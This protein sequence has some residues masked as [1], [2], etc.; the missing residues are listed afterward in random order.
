MFRK[1][2][3]N[4]IK[5]VCPKNVSFFMFVPELF[6][7][8]FQIFNRDTTGCPNKILLNLNSYLNLHILRNI[9]Q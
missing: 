9:S 5:I 8:H 3:E 1:N 6:H 7:A 2:Q 4:K